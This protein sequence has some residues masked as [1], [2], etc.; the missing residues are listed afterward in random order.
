MQELQSNIAVAELSLAQA[1][2][3]LTELEEGP[4]RVLLQELESNVTVAELNLSK[5]KEA[6]EELEEGPDCWC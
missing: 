1:K 3:D 6:L 4:D 5:T 2:D